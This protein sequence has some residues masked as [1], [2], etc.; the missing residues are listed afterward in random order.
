MKHVSEQTRNDIISLLNK[1]LSLRKIAPKVGAS[2]ATVS[3]A[4]NRFGHQDIT[5]RGGR[6]GKLSHQD[7]RMAMRLVTSDKVDNAV[8]VAQELDTNI[9][10]HIS[11]Q[12]VRRTL[13]NMGTKA[14]VKKKKKLVIC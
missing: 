9:N 14:G 12:T 8:Q 7:R 11:A 13:K 4:C 2:T 6:P 10:D 5:N 1:N 3:R